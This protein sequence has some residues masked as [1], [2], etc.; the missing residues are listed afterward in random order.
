MIGNEALEHNTICIGTS[1]DFFQ[2]FL[3]RFW[4]YKLFFQLKL[5]VLAPGKHS[6]TCF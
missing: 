6:A 3:V 1:L 5:M 4:L 2:S